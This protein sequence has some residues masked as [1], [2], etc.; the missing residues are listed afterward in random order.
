MHRGGRR[1]KAGTTTRSQDPSCIALIHREFGLCLVREGR[2]KERKH[3]KA[4]LQLEVREINLLDIVADQAS[5]SDDL[6][7]LQ[8]C[9]SD[10]LRSE[11]KTTHLEDTV[12]LNRVD[13]DL[14]Q[15]A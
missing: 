3:I 5:T 7:N 13:S 6:T 14:G 15:V 1:E 9:V 2:V 10:T 12:R 11:D 4:N 8:H